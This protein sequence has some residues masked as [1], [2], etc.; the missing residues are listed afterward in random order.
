[1]THLRIK[2]A[3]LSSFI[4]NKATVFTL[5]LFPLLRLLYLA[6]NNKLTAHPIEYIEHSTGFWSLTILLLLLLLTPIRLVFKTNKQIRF[7]R[8]LG[9]FVFFYAFMHVLT[10]LWLDYAFS[11][12]EI[13]KDVIKHP[14]IWVGFIAFLLL[15]PLAATSNQASI[16]SLGANWVKLHKL[17]Y[18]VAILAVTHFWMLV[19]RDVSEPMVFA[20]VLILLLAVRLYFRFTARQRRA[21]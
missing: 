2:P 19:K 21:S 17:V 8:M 18:L 20:I 13:A 11:Y 4:F 16:K 15:L 1:M 14:R 5:A 7:R 9:L 10:Y 6:L 3:I 12:D